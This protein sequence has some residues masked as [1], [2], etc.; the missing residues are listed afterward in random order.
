M[1]NTQKY[2]FFHIEISI[3]RFID[4]ILSIFILRYLFKIDFL[5]FFYYKFLINDIF[6]SEKTSK[7]KI[8]NLEDLNTISFFQ[9][10]LF[11][12]KF[13]DIYTSIKEKIGKNKRLI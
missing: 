3:C 7:D 4:M 6:L 11:N 5:K 1:K 12:E 13:L 8:K 9:T 2:Y 10:L